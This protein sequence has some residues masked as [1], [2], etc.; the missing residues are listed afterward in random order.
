MLAA[1]EDEEVSDVAVARCRA[2]YDEVA[3]RQAVG[4]VKVYEDAGSTIAGFLPQHRIWAEIVANQ[5]KPLAVVAV[6]AMRY[7]LGVELADRLSRSGEVKLRAAIA[8]LPSIT[9]I[10][11]AAI[12]PGAAADSRSRK[13]VKLGGLIGEAFLPDSASR[14]KYLQAQV[15]GIVDLTLDDVLTWT[16]ATQ[17]K[18]AGAQIVFVRSTEID[19]AGE[20]TTNR[21]ARSIMD[22]MVGDVARCLPKLASVGI[23]N[24]VV[25]ADHGHLYFGA[26]REEAMRIPSPGGTRSNFIVGAGLAAAGRPRLAPSDPGPQARIRD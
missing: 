16:K 11:M 19:A 25:T 18:V 8:A 5:P 9:P 7:E 10:G 17:K 20:N 26:E 3:R 13:G 2:K 23:E 6:D 4:F 22:G 21:Y 24:A 1:V 14:Q 15:P 12:L